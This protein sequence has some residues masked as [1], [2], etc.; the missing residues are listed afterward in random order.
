[1]KIK[2]AEKI[3]ALSI[4]NF[5]HNLNNLK[6]YPETSDKINLNIN[7]EKNENK[8]SFSLYN[9]SILQD[10][11]NSKNAFKYCK[12][13]IKNFI[14][15]VLTNLNQ[16]HSIFAEK[17]L[18]V[19]FY[20]ISINYEFFNDLFGNN[21]KISLKFLNYKL[22]NSSIIKNLQKTENYNNFHKLINNCILPIES[23]FYVNYSINF[24]VLFH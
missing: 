6:A 11:S 22:Q 7:Q 4:F 18:L 24:R 16:F 14:S 9:H 2:K 13:F 1:M 15:V 12:I 5:H 8:I 10:E 17:F 20:W 3:W 21:E 23:M 19:I